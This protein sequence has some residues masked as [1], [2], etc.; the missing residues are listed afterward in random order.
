MSPADQIA[1]ELMNRALLT[2]AEMSF[3]MTPDLC[4]DNKTAEILE[5]TGQLLQERRVK[6]GLQSPI[7]LPLKK[8]TSPRTRKLRF[9]KDVESMD[10]T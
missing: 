3:E 1:S 9:S 7:P 4:P 2:N 10:T 8:R 6:L 5:D